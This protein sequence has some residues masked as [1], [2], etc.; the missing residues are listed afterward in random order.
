MLRGA[1]SRIFVRPSFRRTWA[2]KSAVVAASLA[3]AGGALVGHRVMAQAQCWTSGTNG[4]LVQYA[5]SHP[6]TNPCTYN[7]CFYYSSTCDYGGGDTAPIYTA[8]V[9]N[10][11]P[12]WTG[13]SLTTQNYFPPRV[14][15]MN[16][17]Y[18]GLTTAYVDNYCYAECGSPYYYFAACA[19]MPNSTSC[20]GS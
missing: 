9:T 12:Q 18:C 16:Y 14:C 2:A 1:G 3:L 7:Q 20:S 8:M 6:A 15:G 5:C 17:Y 19:A 11:P 4:Q 13:C 10:P